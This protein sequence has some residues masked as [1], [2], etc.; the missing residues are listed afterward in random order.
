MVVVVEEILC[1]LKTCKLVACSN[2]PHDSSLLKIGQVAI[3][4]TPWNSRNHLFNFRDAY[5]ASR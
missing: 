5:G 2:S 1:Q 3:G 4:R